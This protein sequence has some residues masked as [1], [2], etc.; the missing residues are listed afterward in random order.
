MSAFW[1]ETNSWTPEKSSPK[2]KGGNETAVLGL[3]SDGN[4]L[5]TPLTHP[6]GVKTDACD[7]WD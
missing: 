1:G 6:K 4:R 3:F 5:P 7:R 2:K